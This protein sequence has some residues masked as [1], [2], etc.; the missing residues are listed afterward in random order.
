MN[1]QLQPALVWVIKQ[2][3]YLY[4]QGSPQLLSFV[5][6]T[7]S[8]RYLD[9]V[10]DVQFQE[11]VQ[12]FFAQNKLPPLRAY[13]VV[14]PDALF[15]KEYQYATEEEKKKEEKNFIDLIPYEHIL[16]KAFVSQKKKVVAINADLFKNIELVV[17]KNGGVIESI[18]PYFLTG[19]DKPTMQIIRQLMA[20]P[21]PFRSENMKGSFI[22]DLGIT[23]NK[24]RNAQPAKKNSS[25]FYS[26]PIFAILLT[27]LAIL[28]IQQGKPSQTKNT[29][30]QKPKIVSNQPISSATQS[31]LLKSEFTVTIVNGSGIANK[32]N[33]IKAVLT[34]L[35]FVKVESTSSAILNSQS[36]L[37][38]FKPTVHVSVRD[39][40]Y[41]NLN[42]LLQPL[43][44]Q[45]N[46]TLTSDIV[47]SISKR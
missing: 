3:L 16:F 4:V 9:I 43:N 21:E 15:E 44:V 6:P 5:F 32:E 30:Q 34:K 13:I 11:Q 2:G 38:S 40:I 18:I 29:L 19:Q 31:A 23:S 17:Q 27:V 12:Q 42:T 39:E 35:G 24:V 10:N 14:G 41:S 8:V 22:D 26:L 28:L 25:L 47:I 20:K 33:Q 46:P 36:N 1:Q 7:D 45:E 37:I